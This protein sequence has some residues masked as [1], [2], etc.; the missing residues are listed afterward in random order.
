MTQIEMDAARAQIAIAKNTLTKREQF[1]MAAMQTLLAKNPLAVDNEDRLS[2][3]A[4]DAYAVA[5]MM[6]QH[7]SY[8]KREYTDD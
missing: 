6:I 1:A 7:A 5:D 4:S 3:L 2:T 8:P